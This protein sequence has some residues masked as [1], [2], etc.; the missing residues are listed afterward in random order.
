M[1]DN[2]SA[3]EA[4]KSVYIVDTVIWKQ[5]RHLP[6]E[7]DKDYVNLMEKLKKLQAKKKRK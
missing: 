6:L 1:S 3:S 4:I 2:L 5:K 7:M